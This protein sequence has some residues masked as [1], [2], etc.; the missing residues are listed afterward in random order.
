M[1]CVS[2][3]FL[4]GTH[5]RSDESAESEGD[6]VCPYRKINVFFNYHDDAKDES[7]DENRDIPVP[8]C[9]F[10]LCH[11]GVMRVVSRTVAIV[12]DSLLDI[13]APEENTVS[14]DAANLVSAQTVQKTHGSIADHHGPGVRSSE[15]WQTVSRQ[16]LLIQHSIDEHIGRLVPASRGGA[17]GSSEERL[18]LCIPGVAVVDSNER[19]ITDN[20]ANGKVCLELERH[21]C[22][23]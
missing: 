19:D 22:R 2:E 15:V 21:G 7:D 6:D 3:Q 11:C 23:C 18:R 10:V 1:L 13:L 14:D 4:G 20:Q 12:L 5:E 8:W 17:E 9:L 16:L